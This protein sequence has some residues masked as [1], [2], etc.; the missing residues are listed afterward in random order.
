MLSTALG[1]FLEIWVIVP[2][3]HWRIQ[4]FPKGCCQHD[5]KA[6]LWNWVKTCTFKCYRKYEVKMTLLFIYQSCE[7][8]LKNGKMK[9]KIVRKSS[10]GDMNFLTSHDY[11]WLLFIWIVP[12]KVLLLKY[13]KWVSHLENRYR[14]AKVVENARISFSIS[15]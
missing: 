2:F 9:A 15:P 8:A 11:I 6:F 7:R 13:R 1:F 10:F 4:V 12:K 14:H 5:P 3:W